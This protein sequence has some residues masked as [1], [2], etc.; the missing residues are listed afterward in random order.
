MKFT[1]KQKKAVLNPAMIG[2]GL[3]VILVITAIA[4][5]AT[6]AGARDSLDSLTPKSDTCKVNSIGVRISGQIDVSD[7]AFWGVQPEPQKIRV[8]EV[9]QYSPTLGIAEQDYTWKVEL[10][11][12]RTNNVIASDKGKD[13]HPGG[14]VIQQPEYVL[15]FTINDNNCDELIDDF[16]AKIRATVFEDGN[17][18][19]IEKL[20][21]FR[22]GRYVEQ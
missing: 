10:I 18:N 14:S 3:A 8:S 5:F 2:I 22:N 1:K 19:V 9:R 13:T 4:L 20:V 11:N 6:T 15:D 17:E 21:R 12:T 7:V 16:D